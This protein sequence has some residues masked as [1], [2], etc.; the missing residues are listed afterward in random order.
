MNKLGKLLL[1]AVAII[2]V[3]MGEVEVVKAITEAGITGL[4]ALLL[5]AALPGAFVYYFWTHADQI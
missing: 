3:I 5:A 4:S 1:L 2:L